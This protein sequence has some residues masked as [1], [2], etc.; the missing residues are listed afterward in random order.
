MKSTENTTAISELSSENTQ[1]KRL[2]APMKRNRYG[3]DCPKCGNYGFFEI[4]DSEESQRPSGIR[5]CDCISR[6]ASLNSA[7]KNGFTA[8]MLNRC[9]FEN[10]KTVAGYQ[11]ILKD[12]ALKFTEDSKG[13]TFYLG[14]QSGCGKTHICTAAAT[15]FLINH[16]REVKYLQWTGFISRLRADMYNRNGTYDKFEQYKKADVLYIDDLFKAF[17]CEAL[18]PDKFEAEKFYELLNARYNA[19]NSTTIISS[20]WQLRQIEEFDTALGRRIE[21][22]AKGYCI[23]VSPDMGKMAKNFMYDEDVPETGW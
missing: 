16:N 13:K 5:L 20:E 8:E 6:I 2:L 21:E 15:Y 23:N 7:V 14:G 22:M 4:Y 10:F 12:T 11:K 1:R 9:T 19:K 17:K 3:F 18:K